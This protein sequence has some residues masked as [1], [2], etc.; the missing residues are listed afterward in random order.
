MA[1]Q[2][3]TTPVA[4]PPWTPSVAPLATPTFQPP[5]TPTWPPPPTPLMPLDSPSVLPPP[6]LPDAPDFELD[7]A[8]AAAKEL[9]EKRIA[10]LADIVEATQEEH[11]LSKNIKDLQ[12]FA[13]ATHFPEELRS[14]YQT[15]LSEV[16]A[17]QATQKAR[18]DQ[19]IHQLI[20]SDNAW[21]MS[22]EQVER[23]AKL[24]EK[25]D[26]MVQFVNELKGIA[27]EM[28]IML[29]EL[30]VDKPPPPPVP[31]V[32]S[33]EEQDAMDVDE[34]PPDKFG[35]SEKEYETILDKLAELET[36]ISSVENSQ[37]QHDQ[38]TRE[39]WLDLIERRLTDFKASLAK[40]DASEAEAEDEDE[41]AM[42]D[43][44]PSE[45]LGQL[46]QRVADIS[47]Q[48]T[49]MNADLTETSLI[50][51]TFH[52]ETTSLSSQLSDALQDYQNATQK[53][54]Q[55]QERLSQCMAKQEQDS[56]ELA[57]LQASLNAHLA[58]PPSPPAS[59][60]M[61]SKD[62]LLRI[63]H[64]PLT[65][66]LRTAVKP[67][68]QEVRNDVYDKL[69]SQSGEIYGVVWDKVHKTLAVLDL[70]QAKLAQQAGIP[71]QT[72]QQPK[73]S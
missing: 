9:W 57:A 48:T 3:P 70:V 7:P 33:Q 58:R 46:R 8:N 15:K 38:N 12:S 4:P 54:N 66:A 67:M 55:L 11:V 34:K 40:E 49:T 17:K 1:A 39:E 53:Q 32:V 44:S 56:R 31:P 6:P 64:E 30:G 10:Q 73:S 18:C 60:Q 5:P 52:A 36:S 24:Q 35:L 41:N 19:L 28:G 47:K 68:V 27:G 21:P 43:D 71:Q 14:R 59:P 42:R 20:R 62:I 16:V 69:S 26:E 63:L 50:L 45:T 37:V 23:D 51:D 29:K 25:Y 22:Q 2:T 72:A 13:N 61:P 65:S